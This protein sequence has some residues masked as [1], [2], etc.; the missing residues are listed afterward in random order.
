MYW[1]THSDRDT[2][3]ESCPGLRSEDTMEPSNKLDD[4]LPIQSYGAAHRPPQHQN[5]ICRHAPLI[6]PNHFL[7]YITVCW[8][9]LVQLVYDMYLHT[10]IYIY[11]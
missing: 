6:F 8:R 7:R 5:L 4:T 10:Y 3:S 9:A 1:W 2:Q 11:T